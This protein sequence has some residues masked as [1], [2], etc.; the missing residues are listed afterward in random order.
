[1]NAEP[2]PP[3]SVQASGAARA[4]LVFLRRLLATSAEIGDHQSLLRAVIDETREATNSDVCSLYLWD[5][6]AAELVLTATNGLARDG[7]G[8]VRLAL[9]QGITGVVAEQRH[10]LSV[11]DV[12]L[13]PR[14]HW[15]PGLDQERFRSMLSVPVLAADR[16][17]GVLNIQTTE[18]R[19]HGD[20]ERELLVAIGGHVAGIIERSALVD[21]LRLL[22]QQRTELL[23]MLAHD[24]GTPLSIARSYLSGILS[25]AATDLRDPILQASEELDRVEAR[26]RRALRA[27][28]LNSAASPLHLRLADPSRLLREVARRL[29]AIAPGRVRTRW[30][31]GVALVRCDPEAVQDALLNVADNALKYSPTN[32]PIL[33]ELR[34]SVATV[35]LV[36]HDRGPGEP[37]AGWASLQ[38]PFRRGDAAGPGTGLGL[39]LVRRVVESHGGSLILRRRPGGGSSV[40]IE[41]PA[42]PAC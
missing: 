34:V 36:V 3:L 26:C 20:E 7:I 12:R 19:R 25:R 23:M 8:R 5:A 10:P 15:V 32:R 14:F 29:R 13:E 27:L 38:Q 18:V 39:H 41:L 1:M 17:V 21:E 16:L 2:A 42:E 11:P 6:D 40:A 9:G 33:L 24:I 37:T 31:P 35:A 22:H 4:E 28:Q 30:S